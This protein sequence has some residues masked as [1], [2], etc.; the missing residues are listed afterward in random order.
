M[1]KQ[2][3]SELAS[4]AKKPKQDKLPSSGVTWGPLSA[5]II[6]LL[7]VVLSQIVGILLIAVYP[8]LTHHSYNQVVNWLNSNLGDF[9][10][11]VIAEVFTVGSILLYIRWR[12]SNRRAIGLTRPKP[13][14]ALYPFAAYLVYFLIYLTAVGMLKAVHVINLKIIDQSQ[15]VGV[16][17]TTHGPVLILVFISLVILPP[18]AEEIAFRGFLFSG[19]RKKLPLIW[20]AIITS[21]VFAS[22]HLLE[23]QSGSGLLWIAGIDTF[24]LSL[25][26]CWLRERTGR[27]YAGMGLHALKNL[28]A[29]VSLFLLH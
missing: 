14:D 4:V 12:K 3:T 11:T 29:F 27:L 25:V 9:V 21:L 26:L 5:V 1:S 6:T 13:L 28:I 8:L 7:V 2:E 24:T 10:F 19:L 15:N 22:P 17:T 18:I 23:G 16:S 20:A